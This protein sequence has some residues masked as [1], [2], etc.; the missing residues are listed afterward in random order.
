MKG[1]LSVMLIDDDPVRS[2][3][4]EQ[5]LV[6][7]GYY[8]VRRLDTTEDLTAQI[9]DAQPDVIVVDVDSPDRDTLE[10]VHLATKNEPRPKGYYKSSMT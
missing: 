5:Y 10:D 1:K 4:V 2:A 6:E 3:L 9:E 7:V 8:V